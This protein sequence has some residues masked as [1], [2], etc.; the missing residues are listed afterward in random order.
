M[1]VA[2]EDGTIH[3]RSRRRRPHSP[4]VVSEIV[5]KPG[6]RFTRAELS[7]RDHFLTARY[8]LYAF[9]QGR[10]SWA[11]IEHEPWPLAHATVVTLDQNLIE[12]AGLPAPEGAPLVHYA[13]EIDV[14]I[15]HPGIAS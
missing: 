10:L 9:H 11:Q 4:R 5:V 8:R 6:Q 2:E 12:A 13:A 14:K 3:Y 15:G 7:D 1:Q